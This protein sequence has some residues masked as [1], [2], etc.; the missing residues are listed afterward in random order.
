MD[1]HFVKKLFLVLIILLIF[2]TSILAQVKSSENRIIIGDWDG[3]L[4]VFNI[5]KYK[6]IFHIRE[7]KESTLIATLDSPYQKKYGVPVETV[8]FKQD[9]LYL[10]VTKCKGYFKGKL[11][12]NGQLLEGKWYQ[13]NSVL[14]LQL[15]KLKMHKK[16]NIGN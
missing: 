7:N 3:I 15:K 16:V 8:F 2:T 4:N 10:N 13:N 6:M 12:S 9:S 11:K 14:P 1:T 5:K